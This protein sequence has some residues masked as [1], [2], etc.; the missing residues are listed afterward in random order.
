MTNLV[1][2]TAFINN[3]PGIYT[4]TS[5]KKNELIVNQINR[6]L[7]SGLY[8]ITDASLTDPEKTIQR[9]EQALKGGA[10]IIQYRDKSSNPEQRFQTCV[11]IRKL[12]KQANALFIVNDDVTLAKRVKADGVHLGKNDIDLSEARNQLGPDV[13]IG[14]S[15]Y[16]HFELAKQAAGQGA[17]YVA[18]GS[19]YPSITK[20]EA[21]KANLELLHRAKQDLDIPIVAIGGITIENGRSL[22]EAGADMLA[23]VKGIFGQKDIEAAAREFCSFFKKTAL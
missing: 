4:P 13:L 2:T 7:L 19:F 14:I 11:A 12:T 18:F 5:K 21:V 10:Q 20:P 3:T 6:K 22:V 23:V 15:C 8:A 1:I 9:V 16:N 17:D